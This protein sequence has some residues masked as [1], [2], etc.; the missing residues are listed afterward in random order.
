MVA[1]WVATWRDYSASEIR[2]IIIRS[3]YVRTYSPGHL[4]YLY[5][6]YLSKLCHWHWD[7]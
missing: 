5:A 1:G 2:V 3:N 6:S 7:Y 4:R